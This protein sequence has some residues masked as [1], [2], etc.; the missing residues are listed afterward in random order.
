MGQRPHV[1]ATKANGP[2]FTATESPH[3]IGVYSPR[4][5]EKKW[6]LNPPKNSFEI[7]RCLCA[8]APICVN[9]YTPLPMVWACHLPLLQALQSVS[10]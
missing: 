5:Q 3:R 2:H 1:N 9:V 4:M 7:S 6:Q 8:C 10:T